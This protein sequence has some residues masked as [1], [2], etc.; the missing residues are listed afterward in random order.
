MNNT[1]VKAICT[2]IAAWSHFSAEE[3][4]EA[5]EYCKSFDLIL[6]A[7]EFS[8]AASLSNIMR[9]IKVARSNEKNP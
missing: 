4:Y 1:M 3:I 8:R 9:I 7:I 6:A 5:W 2:E